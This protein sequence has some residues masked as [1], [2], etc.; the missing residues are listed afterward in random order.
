MRELKGSRPVDSNPL[1]NRVDGLVASEGVRGQF[2]DAPPRA[3]RPQSRSRE[4]V[5]P[6]AKMQGTHP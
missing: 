1:N 2:A 6:N 5:K 3:P 4:G